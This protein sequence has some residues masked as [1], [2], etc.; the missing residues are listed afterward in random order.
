[1]K[2]HNKLMVMLNVA[3]FLDRKELWRRLRT[4]IL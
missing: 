4:A 2:L 1:M 3:Y